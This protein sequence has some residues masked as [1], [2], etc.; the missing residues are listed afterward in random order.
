MAAVSLAE[1]GVI[2]NGKSASA[3][4]LKT[5]SVITGLSRFYTHTVAKF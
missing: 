5:V 2:G 1:R 4:C 3:A